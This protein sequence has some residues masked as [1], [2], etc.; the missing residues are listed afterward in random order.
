MLSLK[1]SNHKE[2]KNLLSAFSTMTDEIQ[3][4]ASKAGLAV[5]SMDP[6][7][8]AMV[9]ALIPHT[10]F[11][12]FSCPDETKVLLD[13]A[14][15]TSFF[16]RARKDDIVS[17]SYNAEKDRLSVNIKGRLNHTFAMP[18]LQPEDDDVPVPK[19]CYNSKTRASFTDLNAAVGDIKLVTDHVRITVTKDSIKFSGKGDISE[20]TDTLKTDDESVTIT[21]KEDDP[22]KSTYSLTFLTE[23]FKTLKSVSEELELSLSTD[24]PLKI[25]AL[26]KEGFLHFYLA[27]RIEVE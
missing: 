23:I 9:D 8:V 4:V 27:P 15:L 20:A 17:L 25:D 10:F 5:R 22:I 18:T 11:D 14:E 26:M 21:T 2:F 7:R 24:M 3:I 16:K 1:L 19:I 12:E 6:S 13:L